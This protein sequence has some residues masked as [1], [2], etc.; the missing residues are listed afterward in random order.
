MNRDRVESRSLPQKGCDVF[1]AAK[2][3]RR[4]AVGKRSATDGSRATTNS[5]PEG[6]EEGSR[7]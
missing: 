1:H 6:I 5:D 3:L 7:P 2:R 4:I